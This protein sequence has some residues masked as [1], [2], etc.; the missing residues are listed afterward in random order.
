MNPAA[1]SAAAITISM[2]FLSTGWGVSRVVGSSLRRRNRPRE[3]TSEDSRRLAPPS[4]RGGVRRWLSGTGRGKV[5]DPRPRRWSAVSIRKAAFA[6]KYSRLR[7]V[8]RP[9]GPDLS[10]PE[11]VVPG[12]PAR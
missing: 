3:E 10:L 9:L 2:L 6:R 1:T 11:I 12:G 8:S 4:Q 5:G 7:E